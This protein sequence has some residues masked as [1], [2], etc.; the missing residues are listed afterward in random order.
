MSTQI[1]TI[2]DQ[3]PK[4]THLY[5]EV[6]KHSFKN[7]TYLRNEDGGWVHTLCARSALKGIL[8]YLSVAGRLVGSNPQ[9]LVPQWTC[10]SV[11]QTIQKICSPSNQKT[12]GIVG[13]MVYHQY[14]FK[15]KLKA[16]NSLSVLMIFLKIFFH[17]VFRKLK[18]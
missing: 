4:F 14:G 6:L 13:V 16:I 2:E 1:I 11:H 7:K 3:T 10:N 17:Q 9:I 5:A 12:S 18:I 15:Q 8:G